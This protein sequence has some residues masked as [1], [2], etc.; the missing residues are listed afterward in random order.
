MFRVL[1]QDYGLRK[2]VED[3]GVYKALH[4]DLVLKTV[5]MFSVQGFI[6]RFLL[7]QVFFRFI[8]LEFAKT[9]VKVDLSRF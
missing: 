6:P 3:L 4:H 5:F 8:G 7:E 1:H 9:L 2:V